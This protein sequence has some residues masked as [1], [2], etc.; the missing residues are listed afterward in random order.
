[1]ISDV[2]IS[3]DSGYSQT[4]VASAFIKVAKANMTMPFVHHGMIYMTLPSK[5]QSQIMEELNGSR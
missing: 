2:Q 1:M 5:F 3:N 4:K